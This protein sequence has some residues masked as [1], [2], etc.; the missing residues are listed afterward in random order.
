MRSSQMGKLE[1][2]WSHAIVEAWAFLYTLYCKGK[3]HADK[4]EEHGR[5]F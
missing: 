3:R 5:A 1:A 2:T 4:D